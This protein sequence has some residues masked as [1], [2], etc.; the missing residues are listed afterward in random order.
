[1]GGSSAQVSLLVTC[2]Q[3]YLYQ[4]L[5]ASEEK[6]A[7]AE[8]ELKAAREKLKKYEEIMKSQNI[9]DQVKDNSTGH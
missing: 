1:M 8:R 9:A 2:S 6:R 4:E 3:D 5:K 7:M